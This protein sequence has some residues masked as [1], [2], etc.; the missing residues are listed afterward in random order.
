MARL[1][2][3]TEKVN[4]HLDYNLYSSLYFV[5]S[6]QTFWLF[7]RGKRQKYKR[8]RLS[9]NTLMSGRNDQVRVDFS[10]LPGFLYTQSNCPLEMM[11]LDWFY[12]RKQMNSSCTF[13]LWTHWLMKLGRSSFDI[14]FAHIRTPFPTLRLLI[15]ALTHTWPQWCMNLSRFS[16]RV[17]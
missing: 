17:V 4:S 8:G 3:M 2:L 10:P 5:H 7:D 14:V 15:S 11:R 1:L 13:T 6:H 16:L 9:L 12:K